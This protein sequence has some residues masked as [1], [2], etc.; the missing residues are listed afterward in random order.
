MEGQTYKKLGGLYDNGSC[1]SGYKLCGDKTDKQVCVKDNYKKCPISE[2]VI[3]ENNPDSN[4]YNESKAYN[5]T[6]KIWIARGTDLPLVDLSVTEDT[7]C[8]GQTLRATADRSLPNILKEPK[9]DKCKT[10]P[11]WKRLETWNEEDYYKINNMDIKRLKEITLVDKK[12]KYSLVTNK[13][14]PLKKQCFSYIDN[15]LKVNEDRKKLKTPFTLLSVA[16]LIFFQLSIIILLM[17]CCNACCE[18]GGLLN[19]DK[20]KYWVMYIGVL[21][22]VYIIFIL[23]L[24]FGYFYTKSLDKDIKFFVDNN[25]SD[26]ITNKIFEDVYNQIFTKWAS[27]FLKLLIV[28]IVWCALFISLGCIHYFMQRKNNKYEEIKDQDDRISNKSEDL[29]LSSSSDN[30][31][32]ELAEQQYKEAERAE[33]NNKPEEMQEKDILGSKMMDKKLMKS[34]MMDKDYYLEEQL[35]DNPFYNDNPFSNKQKY[36]YPSYGPI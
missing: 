7:P 5:S 36:N 30:K 8:I 18:D 29:S 10:D 32:A 3:S 4:I 9:S 31:E 14:I 17:V 27:Y 16:V 1:P 23:V 33:T 35:N 26:E 20:T 15:F 11:R 13:V 24:I 19:F 12:Y 22:F 21:L 28:S 6:H 2:L 25:C 34:G